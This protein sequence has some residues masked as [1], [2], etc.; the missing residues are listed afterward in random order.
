MFEAMRWASYL[1]RLATPDYERWLSAD[2]VFRMATEASAGVLGP[3]AIG[4]QISGC[5]IRRRE[6]S[7][8]DARIG[9]SASGR[10]ER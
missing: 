8:A 2:E 10:H 6:H 9:T 4:A 7:F 3:P 5:S 1:S